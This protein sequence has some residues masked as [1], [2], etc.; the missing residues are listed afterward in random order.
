M[1][2]KEYKPLTIPR[3]SWNKKSLTEKY[4]ELVAQPLEPGFGDTLGNALRRVLLAAVEG[5]AVT[6][7]KIKGI[8]NEFSSI[9]G[10]IEDAMQVVLNIKGIVIKNLEGKPGT[11]RLKVSGEKKACVADIVADPHL[12]LV[13][14]DHV[15]AHVAVDG[16]LDIEFF[17][18]TG[19]EYQLA[20]WPAG[21]A[22][23]EDNRVY[24]DA[25]FSPIRNV[26]YDVEKTRVGQDINYDKLSL[27]IQTDGSENPAEVLHY[28]VSVLRTQ[29]EHFLATAEIPF[30]EISAA[31]QQEADLEP[32]QLDHLGLKGIPVELLLKPIEELELSVRAHNCLINAGIKRVIDLVNASED[33]ILKIKNFGRKS[34]NE[35]K[36]SMKAFGLSF[37]MSINEEDIKKL[38][39]TREI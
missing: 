25:M 31:P 14:L 33:D 32:V 20:Q 26:T 19:R 13:N 37:S 39:K 9:P 11:M 18:D 6:S 10:V 21:V 8:N 16:E 2:K 34:L 17:V 5:S 23:Q 3:V 15:I 24:L 36:D 35:V 29:L 4:G 28:A 12:V 7:V 27:K 22:Y 30:N 38:L 1:N